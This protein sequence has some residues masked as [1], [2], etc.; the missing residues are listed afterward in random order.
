[1]SAPWRLER[2]ESSCV[3]PAYRL[4]TTSSSGRGLVPRDGFPERCQICCQR[5]DEV[6]RFSRHGVL[7][8]VTGR[9]Q[10]VTRQLEPLQVLRRQEPVRRSRQEAVI[11]PVELVA[12]D[13][14]AERREVHS[15]LMLPTGEQRTAH[16]RIARAPSPGS[17]GAF[18]R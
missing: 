17:R 18:E 1:M 5:S 10:R 13:G 3:H 15:D 8:P 14:A 6:Q 9:M 4:D 11:R 16:E 2:G 7:E 12:D